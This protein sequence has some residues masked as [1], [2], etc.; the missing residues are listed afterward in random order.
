MDIAKEIGADE[1]FSTQK[2][3]LYIPNQGEVVV[4][5]DGRFFRMTQYDKP[6]E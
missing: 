1:A 2:L 5:F 4:E 6:T 3:C